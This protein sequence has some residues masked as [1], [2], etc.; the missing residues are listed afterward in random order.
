MRIHLTLQFI[1]IVA[2]TLE[3]YTAKYFSVEIDDTKEIGKY[4]MFCSING[5]TYD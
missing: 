5:E 4:W 3:K 1:A 2:I